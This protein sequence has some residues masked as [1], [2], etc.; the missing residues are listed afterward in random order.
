MRNIKY[1]A[2]TVTFIS[3]ASINFDS[4]RYERR[5]EEGKGWEKR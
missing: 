2:R 5:R 3:F 4:K 1:V